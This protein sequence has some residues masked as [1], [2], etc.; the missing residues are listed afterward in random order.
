[1]A[2]PPNPFDV[3]TGR[4]TA[5]GGLVTSEMRA[6]RLADG[7]AQPS[8]TLAVPQAPTAETTSIQGPQAAAPTQA[9]Q[10][11]AA[12]SADQ[13]QAQQMTVDP[14]TQTVQGQLAAI[15][16]GGSPLLSQAQTRAEQQMQRRGL[17]NSS[18]AAGAAESAL[19]DAALPI[20]QQDASTYAGAEQTNAG[21]RQQTE[22]ANVSERNTS[23]R[24]GFTESN[25]MRQFNAQEANQTARQA[26]E[27]AQQRQLQQA[28]L[29]QQTR[30]A[31]MES[32]NKVLLQAL[33]ADTR[34]NMTNIEA[35][36]KTLMQASA[37]ASDLYQQVL[38]NI[39]EITA[40]KDMD[41]AAK[42]AAIAQQTALLQ[43]GMNLIGAM[44]NLGV[45]DLLDFSG[46]NSFQQTAPPPPPAASGDNNG[47]GIPDYQEL[48]TG[49]GGSY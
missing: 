6:P 4:K 43:N 21:L 15:L 19:Y 3:S 26:A 32:Q 9:A 44:N 36:Y 10:M 45:N 27:L 48:V 7:A 8:N 5:G 12:L 23:N 35:N 11:P 41:A 38:R 18:M 42:N 20:A 37:S 34:V 25:T 13:A 40:N 24:L 46:V 39:S 16:S 29:D 33:D 2:T 22:L 14:A 49:E 31:N 30:L 1:M 28:S 17:V 47:N